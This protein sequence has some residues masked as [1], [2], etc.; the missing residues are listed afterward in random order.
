MQGACG[1]IQKKGQGLGQ[2]Y[3]SVCISKHCPRYG[4]DI[5]TEDI[6]PKI[7]SS[8]K[9]MVQAKVPKA[10]EVLLTLIHP[11]M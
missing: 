4:I 3:L 7:K 11:F 1:I 6:T 2:N 10:V 8:V 5:K 9:L